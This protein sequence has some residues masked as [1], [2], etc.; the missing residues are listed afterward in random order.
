[1][2]DDPD[3]LYLG[4]TN[5]VIPPLE[6]EGRDALRSTL[7]KQKR[8]LNNAL[9][10]GWRVVRF[11]YTVRIEEGGYNVLVELAKE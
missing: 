8:L 6:R 7:E 9:A 4:F 11:D 2:K 3:R 1:M 5:E 10:A